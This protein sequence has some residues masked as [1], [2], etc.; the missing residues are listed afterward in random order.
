M[1]FHNQ[2]NPVQVLANSERDFSS[3]PPPPAMSSD[4]VPYA[5]ANT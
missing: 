2:L 3:F 1:H 5:S 4:R